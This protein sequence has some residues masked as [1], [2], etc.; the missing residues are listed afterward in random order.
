MKKIATLDLKKSKMSIAMLGSVL[1][2]PGKGKL[3]LE[4]GLCP[5]VLI[6]V[7][8]F[9]RSQRCSHFFEA[10]IIHIHEEIFKYL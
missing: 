5:V 1:G 9:H 4:S 7:V 8:G 2:E 10:K 3:A 6:T